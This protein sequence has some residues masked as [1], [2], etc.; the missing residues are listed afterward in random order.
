[1]PTNYNTQT[2]VNTAAPQTYLNKTYYDK[3]LLVNAK[4]QLK[5]A[6]FGQK[7][8]IPNGA[9]DNVEFRRWTLFD[10]KKV[11]P[12][13]VEGVTP[14]GQ[15]LAQTRVTAQCKAYGAYVEVSDWLKRTS[16]DNVM[17]GSTDIL[18]EQVGTALDWITRDAMAA[19]TTIQYANGRA[20]RNAIQSGDILTTTEIRKAV[21]TLKKNKAR[22][23]KR[24]GKDY[25]V[26]IVSPDSVYDLQSDQLWQDV[27]KYQYGEQ[28]FS[29]E[30]GKLFGVIFVESTEA[31]V[32]KQSVLNAVN[33]NTS[34]SK[35]FVL[36]NDPSEE[37]IEYF[38]VAGNKFYVGSTEYTVASFDVD[39]K[40]VTFAESATNLTADTV[41][42]TDDAGAPD[43]NKAEADVHGTL[44]FGEDAYGV[45]D[46]GG[47]GNV[48][49]IIH[50]EGSTTD[51]LDQR[52]TVACKCDSYTACILNED[53]I[54]RI[55]H[56]VS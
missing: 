21:R 3:N 16:Y 8:T 41:V 53:W 23:F 47:S 9:G 2:T 33:A 52:T 55:E 12:G 46:I 42:W 29:G 1:M 50:A 28:I 18:G 24:N 32:F 48:H 4:T 39:N 44:V 31:K 7:R 45:V 26:A 34:S 20:S 30:I 49:T 38:S 56:A 17:T 10:P 54:L 35:K 19:G 51:P 25:F 22:P 43:A 40:E 27:S 13:L 14:D 5:H 37:E 36:K 15:S 11:V 6:Q